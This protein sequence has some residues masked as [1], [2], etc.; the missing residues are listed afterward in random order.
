MEETKCQKGRLGV[1]AGAA[2]TRKRRRRASAALLDEE[3]KRQRGANRNGANQTNH[4]EN[5]LRGEQCSPRNRQCAN[6]DGLMVVPIPGRKILRD[7]RARTGAR[8]RTK[9]LT[10]QRQ[11]FRSGDPKGNAGPWVH[12]AG[13]SGGSGKRFGNFTVG[14][15]FF[16][17]RG[18]MKTATVP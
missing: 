11:D 17:D 12:P 14:W 4:H 5:S 13:L 8:R 10:W 7:S 2:A 18:G 15:R 9:L 6:R 3:A 16:H 1:R